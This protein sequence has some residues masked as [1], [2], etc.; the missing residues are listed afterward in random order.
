MSRRGCSRRVAVKRGEGRLLLPALLFAVFLGFAPAGLS[1]LGHPLAWAQTPA[2]PS[3]SEALQ[4]PDSTPSSPEQPSASPGPQQ[5]PEAVV[6]PWTPPVA[7]PPSQ[8]HIPGL[9]LPPIGI[10][11]GAIFEYH[12]RLTLSEEYTD[13]F[14]LTTSAQGTQSNFRTTLSPG[15]T[16][17][18][19]TAKTQGRLSVSSGFTYD[20][21][22]GQD[23]FNAFPS[24]TASIRHSFNPRLSLTLTDSFNRTDNPTVANSS[25]LQQQRQT[26]T[27]NTFGASAD[28]L[29]DL[30]QTQYYY[31]NSYFSNSN[32]N[33]TSQNNT[34]S[35][36]QNST[37]STS[38]NSTTTT[39]QIFGL[40]ASTRLGTL[41]T[42]RVGYE[43][44]LSEPQQGVTSSGNL[45]TASASHQLGTF[46]SVGVQGSHSMQ[47]LNNVTVW[48]G[49][50]F[51]TYGVPTG[52]SFSGSLGYSL[53]NSD[54]A[55]NQ[56]GYS[57]NIAAS[58]AHARGAISLGIFQDYNTTY[59]GGQVGQSGV[60]QSGQNF[61]V[62][63][64]RGYTGTFTY[65]LTPII[66]SF[67]RA[68]YTQ[69][70]N[71][72]IGNTKSNT[73]QDFFTASGGINWPLL[74]WL[75][76]SL[77]VT[78]NQFNQPDRSENRGLLSLSAAF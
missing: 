67:L 51:G 21:S 46:A 71:T 39:S 77:Q 72:G 24:L 55:S 49:S 33:S 36:S 22:T 54:V 61:G 42:V 20:S 12:S 68:S 45:F 14:N 63:Q 9:F 35:T 17:L 19:N 3:S 64:Q 48:N 25:G 18:I 70:T 30:L 16:I 62:V 29:I 53:V 52:I 40:G 65:Q 31:R 10:A 32:T 57:G 69:N 13:N 28:W 23:N 43:Y 5:Q 8:S 1:P 59:Q 41:N 7:P 66:N 47:T 26:F 34:T 37:T 78:R 38:Q 60:D 4:S 58:Y 73:S 50:V 2:A 76:L 27:S 74:R 56:S 44:S 11:P 15:S 6:P 75:S